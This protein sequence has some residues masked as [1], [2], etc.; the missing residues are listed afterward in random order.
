[1]LCSDGSYTAGGFRRTSNGRLEPGTPTTPISPRL[2]VPIALGKT[3]TGAISNALED[4]LRNDSYE[5]L[6]H[7][8]LLVFVGSV[9]NLEPLLM[10][11]LGACSSLHY[12][13]WCSVMVLV[14]AC[15]GPLAV[16]SIL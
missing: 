15:G 3:D 12:S 5:E 7:F 6:L 13:I 9:A 14:V 10:Y 8:R 16:T 4:N 11:V 2:L 1:M